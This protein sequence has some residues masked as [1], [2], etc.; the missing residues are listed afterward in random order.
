MS[1]NIR[2]SRVYRLFSCLLTGTVQYKKYRLLAI[3]GS[4]FCVLFHF[5]NKLSFLVQVGSLL[6]LFLFSTWW[7]RDKFES[8]KGTEQFALV[9]SSYANLRGEDTY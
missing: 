5:S 9:A 4:H 2:D 1:E 3:V 8:E 6:G 7:R